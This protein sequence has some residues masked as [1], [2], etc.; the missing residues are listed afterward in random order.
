MSKTLEKYII[1]IPSI[2]LPYSEEFETL[3]ASSKMAVLWHDNMYTQTVFQQLLGIVTMVVN[4]LWTTYRCT[5]IITRWLP[6]GSGPSSSNIANQQPSLKLYVKCA[7][8]SENQQ[9]EH[10]PSASFTFHA[11]IYLKKPWGQGWVETKLL[12]LKHL[13]DKKKLPNEKP[14]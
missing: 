9:N 13:L 4:F 8:Q 11:K 7:I 12:E 1:K 6:G 10:R 2:N 3:L 5:Y 14:P